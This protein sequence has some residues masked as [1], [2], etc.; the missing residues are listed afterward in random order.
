MV[1]PKTIQKLMSWF[2]LALSVCLISAFAIGQIRCRTAEVTQALMSHFGITEEKIRVFVEAQKRQAGQE[3][4][5]YFYGSLGTSLYPRGGL[6][7]TIRG[8]HI[9]VRPN[10]P[11]IIPDPRHTADYYR[12]LLFDESNPTSLASFIKEA[13]YG[14]CRLIGDAFGPITVD[15]PTATSGNITY[16]ANLQSPTVQQLIVQ[17]A[18][19]ALDSVVDFSRYD[20]DKDGR[21]DLLFLTIASDPDTRPPNGNFTQDPTY[22][23]FT[24]VWGRARLISPNIPP[25]ATTDD[26][27][28]VECAVFVHEVDSLHTIFG[29]GTYAHE[30]GHV[31]GLPDLY[32]P[33]NTDQVDPGC[34]SL[35]AT[36]DRFYPGRITLNPMRPGGHPGHL[37]PWCKLVWGWVT[38]VEVTRELGTVTIPIWAEQ[39]VAYR[40]WAFGSPVSEEY[41]LVVNRQPRGFDSWLPGRGLNIFH[42]DRSILSD[43]VL[44]FQNAVQIDPTRKGVDLVDADDRNDMDNAQI[45]FQAFDWTSFGFAG[46]A[47][48]NWGD[49]GDPFPG[50]TNKTAFDLLSRPPSLSYLGIDSGVRIVDIRPQPDGTIQATLRV[51]TQPQGII[52]APREGEIVYTNRPTLQVQFA[53]PLGGY[54]D[55]DPSTITVLLNGVTLPVANITS[56]FSESSQTL[57]LPLVDPLDPTRPL[58][59][60]THTIEVRAR[61]RAGVDVPTVTTSFTILPFQLRAYRTRTGIFLPFM[62]TLP[63]DFQN[64]TVPIERRRPAY[65]FGAPPLIARWGVINAAG[66]KGYLRSGEFV[67]ELAPGRSYWVLLRNDVVLAVDAPDVNRAQPFRIANESIWDL[68]DFDVGWQQIGNPYPFPVHSSALQVMNRNGQIFSLKDAVQRGLIL[69]TV[70]Y[71]SVTS[72]PP[73]Y[74]AIKV[75]DWLLQPFT[76]YW[77][78][79]FQPCS[80]VVSPVPTPRSLSVEPQVKPM[81]SL[82]VWGEKSEIPYRVALVNGREV[83]AP[84]AA[85]GATA[86]AGFVKYGQNKRGSELLLMEIPSHQTG[87]WWLVVQSSQ[88][89]QTITLRWK[90]FGRMS[91]QVT[92]VDPS[93]RKLAAISGAGEWKIK[94]DELGTKRLLVNIGIAS[95]SPIRIIDLK[96]TKMRGRGYLITGRLT[97]PAVVKAEIRTL[98]GRLIRVLPNNGEP[99]TQIQFIWDGRSAE[100]QVLASTPL[101]LRL[102]ACD[103]LGRETQRVVVLR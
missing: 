52:L 49:D 9:L 14:R 50:S 68:N 41:F 38:P 99:Q 34:W 102:V 82:E 89:N 76:G 46:F 78:Y 51:A 48:G 37:D 54:A 40:L 97:V 90:T 3:L 32:N 30:F 59:S 24:A 15:V 20:S 13:S 1:Q 86:W 56:F 11:E 16:V 36:G 8:L 101:L 93:T 57:V 44:Y 29:C 28:V 77:V 42:I 58:P 2:W 94:T 100:G 19:S 73:S 92:L 75:E 47:R 10:S 70:F 96:V 61:N 45:Q 88:P 67:E 43:L 39:P 53:A 21:I 63:Y 103:N 60:G 17:R 85:P 72:D 98:T 35:M 80:L 64:P 12:R 83:A 22:G 79:K 26:S 62:V 7:G 4:P 71:Y 66:Q 91:R 87:R 81:I 5:S 25:M 74:F 31:F 18:L 95:E 55:I 27:V 23:A 84:P 65:V 69:D 6:A 33:Y